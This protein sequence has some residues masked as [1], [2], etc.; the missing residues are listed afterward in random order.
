MQL[1]QLGPGLKAEL[2]GEPAAGVAVNRQRLS[3]AP[4]TV[5]RQHQ[6]AYGSFPQRML[7][8]QRRQ[9]PRYLAMP[10]EREL[11][12]VADLRDSPPPLVPRGRGGLDH[13]ALDARQGGAAPQRQGRPQQPGGFCPLT[14]RRGPFSLDHT[15]FEDPRVNALAADGEPV[16]G[17]ACL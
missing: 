15:G 9:F 1:L 2:L 6:L 3:P 7:G 13:Q 4:A 8:Y 5:E 16:T 11:M 17:A 14:G 10:A 12:P